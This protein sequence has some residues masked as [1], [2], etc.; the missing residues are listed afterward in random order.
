VTLCIAAA[1]QDHGKPRIVLCS[2][3]R[4]QTT[5]DSAEIQDKLSF[6]IPNW[7]ALIAGQ[8]TRAEELLDTYRQFFKSNKPEK[9]KGSTI[10]DTFKKPAQ[11]FQRKL[12][13][14]HTQRKLGMS[15]AEFLLRSA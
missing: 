5:T 14:E 11:S 10:I 2:D 13:D 1:C 12:L 8:P 3:L 9:L 4:L 6:R 7:A 15:Y